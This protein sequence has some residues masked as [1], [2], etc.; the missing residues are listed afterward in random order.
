MRTLIDE[1]GH[2]IIV[3][4]VASILILS[5]TFGI[6]LPQMQVYTQKSIPENTFENTMDYTAIA[7]NI[8]R[9]SPSINAESIVVE[10]NTVI[11]FSQYVDAGDIAAVNADGID[12]SDRI[13]I[14][15]ANE[16]SALYYDDVTGE[17]ECQETGEYKFILSVKDITETEYFGKEQKAVLFVMVEQ[18]EEPVPDETASVE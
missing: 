9:A 6:V 4:I 11:D 16:E 18:A 15:P 10:Q 12:I 7:E 14:K 8:E 17:F 3:L 2:T 1:Y 5:A 13:V